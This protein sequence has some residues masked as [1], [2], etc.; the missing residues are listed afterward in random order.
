MPRYRDEFRKII[1]ANPEIFEEFAKIHDL[2]SKDAKSHQNEFNRIGG[3]V[4][5][6]IEEAE[7]HLCGKT[8]RGQYAKYSS[9]LSDKFRNEV[10]AFFPLIDFVGVKVA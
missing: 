1:N 8:E 7:R 5:T 3:Q 2:Y 10:K 6:L 4:V 9:N